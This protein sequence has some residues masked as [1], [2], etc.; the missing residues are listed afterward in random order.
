MDKKDRNKSGK[1]NE[2]NGA[3]AIAKEKQSQIVYT[4]SD[5]V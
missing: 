5:M 4:R 2:N 1:D 3:M